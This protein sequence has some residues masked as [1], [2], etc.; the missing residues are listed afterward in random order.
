MRTPLLAALAASVLFVADAASAETVATRYPQ[1]VT[2]MASRFEALQVPPLSGLE[3]RQKAGILKTAKPMAVE[4]TDLAASLVNQRKVVAALDAPFRADATISGILDSMLTSAQFD[5]SE[6]TSFLSARAD[7]L[8]TG[9]LKKRAAAS[10]ATARR[11][12]DHSVDLTRTRASRFSAL[13]KALAAD[14]TGEK[15]VRKAL[16]AAG[17]V[18]DQIELNAGEQYLFA[19][20]G[21][22]SNA[23]AEFN[24]ATAGALQITGN[25]ESRG[26]QVH[27]QI[28]V[29]SPGLGAH[30]LSLA[31]DTTYIAP[32]EGLLAATS[33][34]M[35]ISAWDPDN[36]KVAGTFDVVFSNGTT[37]ITVTGA[38]FSFIDLQT[39]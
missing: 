38:A 33:G 17:V 14:A 28:R 15:A 26:T 35:Q 11:Q 5:V 27:V 1:L 21:T 22:A 18:V 36:H 29:A 8:P 30:D 19:A 4:T 32:P 24:T 31:G 25:F 3:K 9:A 16:P 7:A 2:E 23:V 12:F 34:T 37:T 20:P 6:R 10:V 39:Q 13:S